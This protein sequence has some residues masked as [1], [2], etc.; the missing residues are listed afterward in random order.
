MQTYKL[1]PE[2]KW[3]VSQKRTLHSFPT[4]FG[5]MFRLFST[6]SGYMF[7]IAPIHHRA[8]VQE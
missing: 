5:H 7:P 1:Q 3:Q 8:P 4:D 6:A 2:H